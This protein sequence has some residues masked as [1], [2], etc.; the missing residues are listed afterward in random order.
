[1]T[2]LLRVYPVQSSCP[3]FRDKMFLV[4]N[5]SMMQTMKVNLGILKSAM[6]QHQY[7]PVLSILIV[8]RPLVGEET[9]CISLVT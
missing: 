3:N 2:R 7:K 8:S 9:V 5:V 4:S 1:M 6:A